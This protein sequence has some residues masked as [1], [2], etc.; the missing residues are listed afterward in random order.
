CTLA[1]QELDKFVTL[2]GTLFPT[3]QELASLEQQ[4]HYVKE[5]LH[6]ATA[7]QKD[8]EEEAQIQQMGALYSSLSQQ[9]ITEAGE[10]ILLLNTLEG[11]LQHA[12][13]FSKSEEYTVLHQKFDGDLP[14]DKEMELLQKINKDLEKEALLCEHNKAQ[15]AKKAKACKALFPILLILTVL[16]AVLSAGAFAIHTILGVSTLF[17]A[18]LSGLGAVTALVLSLNIAKQQPQT[19]YLKQRSHL[20]ERLSAL[21]YTTEDPSAALSHLAEDRMLYLSLCKKE[22]QL[23]A[24]IDELRAQAENVRKTL[25]LFFAPFGYTD[26]EYSTKL[27]RLKKEHALYTLRS[28]QTTQREKE[29]F[30]AKQL[31]H[32]GTLELTARL[33]RYFPT[34]PEQTDAEELLRS[35]RAL[36]K[37]FALLETAC[38]S[39]SEDLKRYQ[40]QTDLA[41]PEGEEC[42]FPGERERLEEELTALEKEASSRRLKLEEELE[43]A[44]ELPEVEALLSHLQEQAAVLND[45]K[46]ILELTAGYLKEAHDDLSSR[47]TL[48]IRKAYEEYALQIDPSLCAGLT[49]SPTDMSLQFERNGALRKNENFNSAF[50]VLSNICMRLAMLKVAYPDER[51]FLVLDDPFVYLDDNNC[52]KALE[53]LKKLS[54][55]TQ[56]LYFTC[57]SGRIL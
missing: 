12:A 32:T 5:Q 39:R 42:P 22:E 47:Y 49:V 29:R 54:S 52:K 38:R 17:L 31:A 33:C 7:T 14:S 24:Q 1:K 6:K 46:R 20:Q 57:H 13:N 2:H 3:E 48:P 37:S 15:N 36:S 8:I 10:N 43:K 44:S 27:D 45:R 50:L 11:K 55:D 34:P 16:F 19:E 28:A 9:K 41:L 26:Q 23:Q 18:L 40:A 21:G 56:I 53:A 30:A 4:L 51:P 35:L 25:E